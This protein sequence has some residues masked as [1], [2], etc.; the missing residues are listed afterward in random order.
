MEKNFYDILGITEEEKNLSETDFKKTLNT[1]YKN[2]A[3]KWHPDRFATKSD[4]ERKDAEEKFKEISEAYNTLSDSEKRQQYDFMQNGGGGFNPFEDM[5]VDPFSF[6]RNHN[7]GPRIVKGQNVQIQ[8]DIVLKESYHGGEKKVSYNRLRSCGYC[9]GSGSSNGVIEMCPHCNGTG[10]ITD[11]IQRGNMIQMMSHPCNHCNGTGQ[12]ISSPCPHCNGKGMETVKEERTIEIPK[13]VTTGQYIIITGGGCEAP[14]TQG[15]NMSVNGDL[16]IV[17]N[18]IDE[19]YYFER[20]GDNLISNVKMSVFDGMLGTDLKINTIDDKEITI[21]I[22]PLTEYN[23]I[24][25][26]KGKGMPNPKTH[27][28]GDLKVVI[29]YEMPKSLN[30]EQRK[31]IK[32]AKNA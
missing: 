29:T 32:R 23:H 18:V 13:G 24:F 7:T 9:N 6:F 5:D 30:N 19:G 15:N 20:E 14:K 31:L 16:I 21:N 2:L 22:P 25:T 1:K 12:K 27:V 11:R 3:K 8:V 28:Y 17:F 10:M 26:I 4:D